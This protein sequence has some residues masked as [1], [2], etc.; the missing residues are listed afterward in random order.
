MISAAAARAFLGSPIA[1]D[2]LL[3]SIIQ[4][5]TATLSRDLGMYLGDVADRVVT[6][7]AAGALVVVPDD[8]LDPTVENPIV[9]AELDGNWEWQTVDAA[10]YRREGRM[11]IHRTFWTCEFNGVRVSFRSG[12][13]D[14][15]GPAELRDLVL[16]LVALRY[17]DAQTDGVQSETLSDYSYAMKDDA[18]LLEDWNA[19]VKAYSRRIPV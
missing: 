18:K 5:A 7:T 12:W 6:L 11:F 3:T 1:D 16:R 2:A 14:D 9:V 10:N 15:A 13:A 19:A 4:R 17:R 8:V